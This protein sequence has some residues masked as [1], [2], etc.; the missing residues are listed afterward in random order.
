MGGVCRGG[1]FGDWVGVAGGGGRGSWRAGAGP[2]ATQ[3]GEAA[4]A[5]DV[6][7]REA[8]GP[9]AGGVAVAVAAGAGD[10]PLEQPAGPVAGAAGA[11]DVPLQQPAGPVP[12]VV[13]GVLQGPRAGDV[14]LR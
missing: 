3:G 9:V 13:A 5:S 8:A 11:G 10:V 1:G 14:R 4:G 7:L 6:P 2:V 12:G